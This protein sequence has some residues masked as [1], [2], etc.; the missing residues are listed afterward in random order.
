MIVTQE[1]MKKIISILYILMHKLEEMTGGHTTG[2]LRKDSGATRTFLRG[3]G[4]R[5]INI[6]DLTE[7][8]N[9]VYTY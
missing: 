1:K 2:E 6:D 4:V 9:L 7:I 3:R 8:K 5:T